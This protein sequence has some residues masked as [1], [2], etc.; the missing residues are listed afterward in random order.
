FNPL[1]LW[2]WYARLFRF[3]GAFHHPQLV[4]G[5]CLA[6]LPAPGAGAQ[7]LDVWVKGPVFYDADIRMSAI[8][9][10]RASQF[11]LTV[12]EETRPGMV[13]RWAPAHP[14]TRLFGA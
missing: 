8:A 12:N 13:G 2:D 10:E 9:E 7:R 6:R 1:H 11:A 14:A 4:I 3:D 5:Q